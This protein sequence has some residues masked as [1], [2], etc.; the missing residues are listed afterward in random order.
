MIVKPRAYI[1]EDEPV[2]R[3]ILGNILDRRGYEVIT[4]PD[5]SACPLNSMG[6]CPCPIGT[7]CADVIVSDIQMPRVNGIDFIQQL[8]EKGCKS[9]H[10]ALMS[11][12]WT[13]RDLVRAAELGCKILRK[14]F[15]I[16]NFF[17][18]LEEAESKIPN[19]R[20]LFDLVA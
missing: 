14:P 1:F 5:P 2:I 20:R 19:E 7:I 13:E 10:I 15:D 6:R 17:K 4:Y 18:W 12:S 8:I 11:G 9:P 3:E 16:T